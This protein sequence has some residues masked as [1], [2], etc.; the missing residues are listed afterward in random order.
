[1]C[2]HG[3]TLRLSCTQADRRIDSEEGEACS[4]QKAHLLKALQSQMNSVTVRRVL[5]AVYRHLNCIQGTIF[6]S[7]SG[8]HAKWPAGEHWTWDACAHGFL[9]VNRDFLCVSVSVCAYVCLCV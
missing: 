9:I 3:N 6:K 2:V 1:M 7:V 5:Q 8:V 4:G